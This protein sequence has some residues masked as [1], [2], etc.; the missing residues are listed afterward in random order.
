MRSF[1]LSQSGQPSLYVLAGPNGAGKSTFARLF[2]PEYADCQEFVNADLIAAGLSPFNPDGA[3]LQAGRHMLERI[4]ALAR[5]RTNFG[6][7]TTL[8]GRSWLPLL[9]RLRA[10]G[11]RLHLFFLW[12][13]SP[14]LAVH[15]VHDRVLSGGHSVPEDVVRRR[16]ARGLQNFFRI[17][18][19]I[20]DAWLIF[21]SSQNPPF[22]IG[23]S[24][25]DLQL[26]FDRN[27]FE[28]IERQGNAP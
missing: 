23:F 20:V 19:P 5:A 17:Y 16:F 26:L 25:A 12:L 1:L 21:D 7:E 28:T 27:L 8:A 13:P 11:Y 14:E 2:L 15:R 24:V 10:R 3:A 22:L 4:E 9:H 6:F 18:A